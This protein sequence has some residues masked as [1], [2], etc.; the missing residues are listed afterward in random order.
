MID[1]REWQDRREIKDDHT[2]G[3]ALTIQGAVPLYV[4]RAGRAGMGITM[5]LIYSSDELK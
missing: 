4:R 3:S 5:G 2:T 1:V